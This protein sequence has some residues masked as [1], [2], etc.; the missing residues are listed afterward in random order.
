MSS[1]LRSEIRR[2][3]RVRR[4]WEVMALMVALIALTDVA[5]Y[6][7]DPHLAMWLALAALASLGVL[8]HL[9]RTPR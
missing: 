8:T 3:R 7:N 9:S 1:G 5:E 2:S 6:H 4:S